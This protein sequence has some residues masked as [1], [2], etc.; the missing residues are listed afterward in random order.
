[1]TL[2]D[3]C[4]F[5]SL[6]KSKDILYRDE[7]CYVIPD[8][9]P[10]SKGHVLVV[11][12]RHF[13]D[14]TDADDDTVAHIAVVAKKFAVLSIERLH[15]EGVN[16]GTNIGRAAGQAIMHAHIHVIPRY[17]GQGRNFN[18]GK[19]EEIKQNEKEELKSILV[20]Q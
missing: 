6:S 11:T 8:K 1:V 2:T 3:D 14:I 16:V 10:I 4:I 17:K 15:A 18:Y 7:V 13:V 9:Y 12:N 19:N 5:C 20:L